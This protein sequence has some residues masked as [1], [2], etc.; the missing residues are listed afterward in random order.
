MV[1]CCGSICI[2]LMANDVQHHFNVLPCDVYISSLVKCLF[3]SFAHFLIGLSGFFTVEFY[4][5]CI[6][7]RYD[8]FLGCMVLKFFFWLVSCFFIP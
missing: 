3:I 4:K 2:F 1:F 6:Y 5:F 7:F 8:P